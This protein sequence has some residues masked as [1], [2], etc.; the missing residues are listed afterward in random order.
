MEVVSGKALVT[1]ALRALASFHK[2]TRARKRLTFENHVAPVYAWVEVA[3]TDYIAGFRATREK[4]ITSDKPDDVLKFLKDIRRG[5]LMSRGQALVALDNLLDESEAST[6]GLPAGWSSVRPFYESCKDYL[7]GATAPAAT[8]WYTEYINFVEV[9]SK[10]MPGDCWVQDVFG[11]DAR[12][13][14][15]F[16]IERT[17]DRLELKFRAVTQ[18]YVLAQRNLIR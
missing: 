11:N 2:E 6:S 1:G 7:Y 18:Q 10:Y 9:S 3:H 4:I 5:A 13:D 8:S 14:L 15:L 12:G 16:A 17:L